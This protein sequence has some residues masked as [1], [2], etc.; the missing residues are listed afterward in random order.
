MKLLFGD[1]NNEKS[2]SILIDMVAPLLKHATKMDV[3]EQNVGQ[4]LIL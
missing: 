4:D 3:Q 1:T 2:K